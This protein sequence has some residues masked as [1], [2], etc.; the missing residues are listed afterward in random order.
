[1]T[2]VDWKHPT[3]RDGTPVLLGQMGVFLYED[4][5]EKALLIDFAS[6]VHPDEVSIWHHG[7]ELGPDDCVMPLPILDRENPA[8]IAATFEWA[9][10]GQKVTCNV[11]IGESHA[12][13]SDSDP[14]SALREAATAAGVRR[15]QARA[16]SAQ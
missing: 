1:M 16:R 5:T 7:A 6:S 3:W 14:I 9:A 11:T 2:S 13:R 12:E 10:E 8:D 15:L 4:G